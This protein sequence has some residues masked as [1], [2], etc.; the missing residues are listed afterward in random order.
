MHCQNTS[1]ACDDV[2]AARCGLDLL[3]TDFRTVP[4]SYFTKLLALV[5]FPGSVGSS[6]CG[7]SSFRIEAMLLTRSMKACWYDC[8]EE[9]PGQNGP[10]SLM[11]GFPD[12]EHS[13]PGRGTSNL[14]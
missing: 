4:E 3:L 12:T 1:S 11:I 9:R 13:K 6:E 5:I 10:E 7:E 8:S 14:K 2:N